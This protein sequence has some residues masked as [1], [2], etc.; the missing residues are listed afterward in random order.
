MSH[1][2]ESGHKTK[3]KKAFAEVCTWIPKRVSF[4]DITDKSVD[5]IYKLRTEIVHEGLMIDFK[6]KKWRYV[7]ILQ[8]I[9]FALQLKQIGIFVEEMEELLNMA[10][11]VG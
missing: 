6:N 9:T 8:W 11:G 3:L 1:G 5:E 10:F 4:Y 2:R 7:E